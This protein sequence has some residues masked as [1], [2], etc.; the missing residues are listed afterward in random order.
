M[1]ISDQ[2]LTNMVMGSVGSSY[3]TYVNTIQKIV[4]NKNFTKVSENPTDAIKVMKLDNQIAK[5]DLYQSNVQAATNEMDFTYSTLGDISDELTT[6]NNLIIEASNSTNSPE[7]AKAIATEIKERVYS[8]KDKLNAQ[9]LDNY[10]FSGTYTGVKAFQEGDDGIIKYQGSSEKAGARNLTISENTQFQYNI[11]GEKLFGT[12]NYYFEDEDGVIQEVSSDFFTQM[13]ELST[14]LN[15]DSLD[16]KK[17]REKLQVTDSSISNVTQAQGNISAQV[18]KL[19]TTKNLNENALLNLTE[20]KVDIEEVDI[21]K[22]A[23]DLANAQTAMQASYLMGTR[24]L[25]N[26]SLLDYL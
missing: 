24:V 25:N 22:A 18:S 7:A 5:L 26:V 6:I 19:D 9:Y 15:A 21:V 11:T 3:D 1:R 12:Q 16:F 10:I 8:I 4:S 14:L 17:I 23:S 13:N 2:V 20:K